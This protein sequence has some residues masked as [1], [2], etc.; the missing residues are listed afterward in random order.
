MQESERS[1]EE[2]RPNRFLQKSGL[3]IREFSADF[4]PVV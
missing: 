3:K 4:L 2:E 1:R